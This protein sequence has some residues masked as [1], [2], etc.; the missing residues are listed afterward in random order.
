MSDF[1]LGG[2]AG[3]LGGFQQNLQRLQ[4]EA[5][6]TQVTGEAAGGLVKVTATGGQE[7]VAVAIAPDAMDDRE[8]LE[9][10]VRAAVNDALTKAQ[11]ASAAKLRALTAGLPIPPGLIPG[12]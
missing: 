3:M 1:D 10:L 9:D 2:L 4:A 7:I 12:M 8:L 11:E 6:A 5:N